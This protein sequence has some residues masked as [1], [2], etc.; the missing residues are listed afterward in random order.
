VSNF[1]SIISENAPIPD[2]PHLKIIGMI[3]SLIVTI[4]LVLLIVFLLVE[5]SADLFGLPQIF[6]T[7]KEEESVLQEMPEDEWE[8]TSETKILS[9]QEIISRFKLLS[10]LPES[11]LNGDVTIICT[12]TPFKDSFLTFPFS[13]LALYVDD[14]PQQWDYQFGQNTW[15][16]H[17]TLKAGEH[18]LRTQVFDIHF[19]V[20]EPNLPNQP[21]QPNQK[22]EK[23]FSMHKTISDPEQCGTCHE[24]IDKSDFIVRKGYGLTIGE[25]KG[26]ESCL[27]CHRNEHHREIHSKI[28]APETDCRACHAIHGTVGSEKFLKYPKS[29]FQQIF[30]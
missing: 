26:N 30:P 2:P 23:R 7:K 11:T 15:F 22:K 14:I 18:Q 6:E 19:F 25:W 10:P 21:N 8:E 13:T 5:F 3:F 20:E 28:A 27:S 24:L 4:G 29:E 9:S 17:L 1:T 12:S 16:V